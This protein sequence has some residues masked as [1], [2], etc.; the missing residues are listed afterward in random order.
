MNLERILQHKGVIVWALRHGA[1]K[2]ES[3][4]KG[5]QDAEL[6]TAA[7]D[8]RLAVIEELL[9]E[10]DMQGGPGLEGTPMGD[11]VAA[12]VFKAED[13]TPLDVGNLD[14]MLRRV[15]VDA[16]PGA[17]GEWS[18]DQRR[19]VYAWIKEET[20]NILNDVPA[21]DRCDFPDLIEGAWVKNAGGATLEDPRTEAEV[22]ELV[23]KGPWGVFS[24][25]PDSDEWAIR[26]DNPEDR[27]GATYVEHPQKY[28]QLDRARLVAA[29]L[30]AMEA[31]SATI[32]ERAGE[33]SANPDALLTEEQF[34]EAPATTP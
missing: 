18:L 28:G 26:K 4:K 24:V 10:L 22:D 27:T 6:P 12:Q 29:N 21:D 8:Q 19:E 17:L 32:L 23:M 3:V 16:P 2:V 30:N 31:T 15:G 33:A 14:E 13:G 34:D 5:E 11:A 7:S 20:Q 9:G 25:A 1:K